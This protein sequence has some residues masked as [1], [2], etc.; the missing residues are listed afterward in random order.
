MAQGNIPDGFFRQ[1]LTRYLIRHCI[2]GIM[3]GWALLLAIIWSD[4]GG[5]GSLIRGSD[6]GGLAL[7]MLAGA[8]AITFGSAGMG[9]AANRLGTS[10]EAQEAAREA[11]RHR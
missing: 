8:F 11:A 2:T 5:I 9:I 1:R 6:A 10:R 4:L 3:V 7:T